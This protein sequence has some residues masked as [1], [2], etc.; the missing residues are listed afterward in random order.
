MWDTEGTW[1]R[2]NKKERLK[3]LRVHFYWKYFS[4]L[5]QQIVLSLTNN[6]LN[7]MNALLCRCLEEKRK[8][9]ILPGEQPNFNHLD[10][11]LNELSEASAGQRAKVQKSWMWPSKVPFP[12]VLTVLLSIFL[13]FWFYRATV[14]WV[15]QSN[16]LAL[17]LTVF[18][19][20]V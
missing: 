10:E 8:K 9:M 11:V 17:L 13:S 12:L 5:T 7:F 16:D 18:F 2:S 20:F 15:G 14:L 3:M 19:T 6:W 1:N 4:L